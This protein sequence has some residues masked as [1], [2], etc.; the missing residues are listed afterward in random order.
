[1]SKCTTVEAKTICVEGMPAFLVTSLQIG[2]G[3]SRTITQTLTS[4]S[5]ET[6]DPS[7]A[8]CD[9]DDA[10]RVIDFEILV[11]CDDAGQEIHRYLVMMSDGTMTTTDYIN[12]VPQMSTSPS[13]QAADK[14]SADTEASTM[15]ATNTDEL[16]PFYGRVAQ[17]KQVSVHSGDDGA[18][19]PA[20]DTFYDVA[21]F[22]NVDV[23]ALVTAAPYTLASAPIRVPVGDVEVFDADLTATALP[24]IPPTATYAEVYIKSR[25]DLAAGIV[26]STSG[27][28]PTA[29]LGEQEN[30]GGT[31]KLWDRASIE[32]FQAVSMDADGQPVAVAG[33]NDT[34]K[35]N[36]RF[37]NVDPHDD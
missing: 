14:A 12:G 22:P 10:L 1:M 36:V 37:W 27:N 24:N 20:L 6:L 9:G 33:A 16:D 26:W 19:D 23:T 21:V 3:D 7:L 34:S 30:A 18:F 8:T 29:D 28:A 17:L 32:R 31:I 5:G 13:F 35:L 2:Y 15:Y 11:G 25:A 4:L